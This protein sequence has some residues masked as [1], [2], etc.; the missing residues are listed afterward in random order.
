MNTGLVHAKVKIRSWIP[1]NKDRIRQYYRPIYMDWAQGGGHRIFYDK[2]QQINRYKIRCFLNV[3]PSTDYD[4]MAQDFSNN[5]QSFIE[6]ERA[7]HLAS[8][9][10][11]NIT[12]FYSWLFYI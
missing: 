10:Q 2:I 1:V 4:D 5:V 7:K 8:N 11:D 3:H 9:D 6:D 12:S